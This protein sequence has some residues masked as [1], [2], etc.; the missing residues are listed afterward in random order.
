VARTYVELRGAQYRLEV[1]ERNAENQQSTFELTQSLL[2]GGRGTDLDLARAEAQL[3]QTLAGLPLLRA[4]IVGAIHRLGVLVGQPPQSLRGELLEAKPLPELPAG[5]AIAD[6]AELLRR[7]PDVQSA[8][9]SLAALTARIGVVTAELFPR[10]TL[11]GSLGVLA[12]DA[13]D[14]LDGASR[15]TSIGPFLS[16]AAFDLG[17]VRR[18]ID[19]SEAEALA[20]VAVYERTVLD[21]LEEAESALVA[22]QAQRER[23]ARLA[24]AADAGARA[25]ELARV[26]YRYGADSFLSVLDAERRLLE[27]QDDVAR[28]ATDAGLA[29]V[30]VYKSLGGGWQMAVPDLISTDAEVVEALGDQ[31]GQG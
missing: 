5:F 27:A 22:Y 13:G 10:V 29:Y 1:A 23:H 15:Q 14:L 9:R 7:R 6:P 3:Q 31:G 16:W 19:A 12:T 4:Q 25:A 11:G 17:R 26:R 20:A 2:E 28:S 8:E 18:R 24:I 21:A 30:A